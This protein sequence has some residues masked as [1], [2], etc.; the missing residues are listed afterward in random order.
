[1]PNQLI[2]LSKV[3]IHKY[4]CIE[5][6]QEF[7]VDENTTVLVGMNESGKTS[8]LEV[9]AKTN[10]FEDDDNFKLNATHDYPRKEKKKM[11]KSDQKA[12]AITCTFTLT[13]EL[14]QSIEEDLGKGVFTETMPSKTLYY[15]DRPIWTNYSGVDLK[16]FV[17][18]KL[19]ELGYSKNGFEEKLLAVKSI[20]D[21][22]NLAQELGTDESPISFDSLKRYYKNSWG[23]NGSPLNEYV[24][25]EYVFRTHISKNLPKYLYYDEYYTLPS[26][27]SIEDMQSESLEE[28]ELKTAKALF[29]LADINTDELLN[30]SEFEDFKAELEATQASISEELFEYWSANQNLDIQFDID[31]VESTQSGTNPQGQAVTNRIV[32]HILDIRVRNNTTRVSLP[33]K[34]RSK[35]FNWFFSF[36]VWFKKIQEDADSAYVILLDEPGLNLHASAQ[37]DLLRFIEDL[38]EDY[39]IIYTT[40]SPFMVDSEQLNR[41]RTVVETKKGSSISTTIQE[42]DPRTLFPLQAALGYDIAQNLFISKNN[43]LVEGVSDLI[44]L[45]GVSALLEGKGRTYLNPEVTIVPVGGLEKVATFVSLLRGSKLNF[46]CLLD[47]SIDQSSQ[48]RLNNMVQHKIIKQKQIVYFDEFVTGTEA[49]IEDLFAK[50]EYL[51]LFNTAFDEHA[52]IAEADLDAGINRVI[53]QINT[54]LGV[55]RFNHYRPANEFAK[56]EAAQSGLSDATLDRFEAVFEHVNK[57]FK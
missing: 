51:D 23:W 24:L 32:E 48:D 18:H 37:A 57:F 50:S 29:E 4:K 36:L 30:A 39:Q 44:Y 52:E 55:T 3:V 12:P 17:T 22:E 45:Q 43:L 28:S 53:A 35:G 54:H 16:K 33:L 42:K 40:H 9:L 15:N 56:S 10:Y 27:I 26:R 19:D 20:E 49:D 5:S 41:V 38:S 8:I 25:N 46:G 34:N 2:K 13:E 1:M 14:L 31:K 11:D 47:S 6:D 7:D 21:L